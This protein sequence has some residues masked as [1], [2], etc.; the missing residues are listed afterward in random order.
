[1]HLQR[2]LPGQV[3][4]PEPLPP[5]GTLVALL[6]AL[7]VALVVELVV[8][9]VVAWVVAWVVALQGPCRPSRRGAGLPRMHAWS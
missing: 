9:L 2:P 6:G 1:M 7:V 3:P 5:F 8:A 4:D